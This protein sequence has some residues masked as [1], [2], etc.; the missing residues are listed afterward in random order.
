MRRRPHEHFCCNENQ[1]IARIF[2]VILKVRSV[3]G[4]QARKKVARH[5]KGAT[6]INV[7]IRLENV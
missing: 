1:P 4:V 7:A 2:Q 3:V 5:E 6:V